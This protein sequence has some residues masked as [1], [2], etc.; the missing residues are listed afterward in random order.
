MIR[1]QSEDYQRQLEAAIREEKYQKKAMTDLRK[2]IDLTL[3]EYL[4]ME[5]VEKS[6]EEKAQAQAELNRRMEMELEGVIERRNELV[7]GL[8]AL[9][10][11]R[12]LKVSKTYTIL[13]P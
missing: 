1:K 12:E 9:K 5:G 8:E 7:R 10:G 3:F 2:E 6:E 13:I 4:K 11:E